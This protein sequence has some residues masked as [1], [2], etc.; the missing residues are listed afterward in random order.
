MTLV[1]KDILELIKH[2][3]ITNADEKNVGS[4]SYDLT[5]KEIIPTEKNR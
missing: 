1:D 4:I 5:T 2:G 3:V